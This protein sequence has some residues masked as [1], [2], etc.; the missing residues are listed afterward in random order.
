MTGLL[1]IILLAAMIKCV[2]SQLENKS[3]PTDAEQDSLQYPSGAETPS[4]SPEIADAT[5]TRG[6]DA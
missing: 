2:L 4:S 5:K 6:E 1:T 3:S